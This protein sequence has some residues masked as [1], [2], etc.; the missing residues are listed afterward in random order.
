ML[1]NQF[2]IQS[3]GIE[4]SQY[5]QGAGISRTDWR[6]CAT[7]VGI[8]RSEALDEALES[9]YQNDWQFEGRVCKQLEEEIDEL[10]AHESSDEDGIEDDLRWYVTV[11]VR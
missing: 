11:Y 5:F 2:K 10:A 9:L 1:V 7:G 4:H 8:S 6:D 3:H